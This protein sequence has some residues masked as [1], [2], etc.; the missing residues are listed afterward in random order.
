MWEDDEDEY[1]E[2]SM[3]RFFS[4][5]F[6]ESEDPLFDV[7]SRSLR[8]LFRVEV[9]EEFVVVAMDLPGVRKEDITVTCTEELV[10]LEAE[11]K[12]PVALRVSGAGARATRFERYSK[13][14]RLPVR[15]VPEKATAKYKNGVI[16][17]KL[18]IL[19]T[20]KAI[21]IADG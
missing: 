11:M 10:S 4:R 19:R 9:N 3:N 2:T 21:K 17:V 15:V 8:P 18:P 12:K 16:V 14:V 5:V 7:Q 13:K 1:P 20:G 6:A